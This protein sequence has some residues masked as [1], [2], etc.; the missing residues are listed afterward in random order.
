MASKQQF[1]PIRPSND[2]VGSDSNN[3]K[4]SRNL[5]NRKQIRSDRGSQKTSKKEFSKAQNSKNKFLISAG[6]FLRG[7][8][9]TYARASAWLKFRMQARKIEGAP[10]SFRLE[11]RKKSPKIGSSFKIIVE[12]FRFLG[13]EWKLF[14]IITLVYIAFY[15]VLAYATPNIDLGTV[16]KNASEVGNAPGVTDKLKTLSSALFTYR[17]AASDFSRWAQF[18][19]A[20]IFSLIFI[21]AL[22]QRH[23]GVKIRARDA[24]YSGT[25][26]LIPYI[27]SVAIIAL[28]LIPL[29]LFSI[30]YGNAAGRGYLINSLE[31]GVAIGLIAGVALITL[32]FLPA[33]IISTYAC[34]IPG[35]YPVRSMQAARIMV[36]L[37]RLESLRYF[38]VFVI[39]TVVC[40]LALLLILVTYLPRFANLSLDLFF[41]VALP[42]IH[43]MMF[44]L[45]LLLLEGG[46]KKA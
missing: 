38:I 25:A 22:R 41:L 3:Q 31:Q 10:R 7:A 45:Y 23:N 35:V 13:Q 2:K 40:Y 26:N 24:L 32:Y 29:S 5:K 12:S 27:I 4:D 11:K 37:R 18:V 6:Y 33:A 46:S 28:Q 20:L 21:Y 36:S 16:F 34:T 14:S 39:F 43:T 30:L 1:K 19:L 9:N 8:E 15:F 44:E 17:S 42:V